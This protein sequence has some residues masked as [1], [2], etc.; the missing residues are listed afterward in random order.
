MLVVEHTYSKVHGGILLIYKY[1]CFSLDRNIDIHSHMG[2]DY[3]FDIHMS[4]LSPTMVVSPL[5][6]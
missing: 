1:A 6:Y 5:P 2:I 3:Y 4:L